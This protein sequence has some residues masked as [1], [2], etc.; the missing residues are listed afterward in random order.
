MEKL[1]KAMKGE[2]LV[3]AQV[4]PEGEKVAVPEHIVFDTII[5]Y[6]KSDNGEWQEEAEQPE[7]KK[8]KK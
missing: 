5:S 2:H 3:F 1:I 7:Q 8:G 4:F 6:V